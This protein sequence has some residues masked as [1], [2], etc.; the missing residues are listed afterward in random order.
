[1]GA[2][3]SQTFLVVTWLFP[4]DLSCTGPSL[5]VPTVPPAWLQLSRF[6]SQTATFASP[7][8]GLFFF[9]FLP[10]LLLPSLL[11]SYALPPLPAVSCLS[12]L[13]LSPLFHSFIF[14]LPHLAS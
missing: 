3:L 11:F 9:L 1:M 7:W 4:Y 12:L 5:L 14:L 6:T 2:K 10:L 13:G 8:P